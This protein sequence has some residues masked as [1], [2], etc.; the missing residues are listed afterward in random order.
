MK[1]FLMVLAMVAMPLS[2]WAGDV[3]YAPAGHETINIS[4]WTAVG[5]ST[6]SLIGRGFGGRWGGTR[7]AIVSVERAP[8]RYWL[9]GTSPSNSAASVSGHL[10]VT[11]TTFN[12]NGYENIVNFRAVSLAVT[13]STI[14]VDYQVAP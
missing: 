3:E 10:V 7:N 9:D 5:F 2:L 4:S 14:H 8:I 13:S 6:A 12:V 1:R 11:S